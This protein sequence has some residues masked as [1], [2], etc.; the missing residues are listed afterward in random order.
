MPGVVVEFFGLPGSGK[1][2]VCNEVI[3]ILKKKGF[4]VS[5]SNEFTRWRQSFS[6]TLKI[7]LILRFLLFFLQKPKVILKFLAGTNNLS[8]SGINRFARLI[9]SQF[10]LKRF[11]CERKADFYFFDQWTMQRIWSLCV[12]SINNDDKV[13]L[14]YSLV[15]NKYN[16]CIYLVATPDVV[17]KR[18]SGRKHGS[19]RFET[20]D[21]RD[22][23]KFAQHL[24]KFTDKISVLL[25]LRYGDHLVIN[26][27]SS[28]KQDAEQVIATFG[29][30]FK[31]FNEK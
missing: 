13:S 5:D 23:L 24:T 7:K 26:A 19:S 10:A 11:K 21:F 25:G 9:L 22:A 28:P 6:V 18:L 16:F 14:A 20:H 4:D 15:L 17:A 30:K 27:S 8:V 31:K 2:T 1:T 12:K 3:G 29:H